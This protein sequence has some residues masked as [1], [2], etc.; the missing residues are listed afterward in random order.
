MTES[1]E[2]IISISGRRVPYRIVR[3]L[4]AKRLRVTVK[5][6]QV[7]VTLPKGVHMSEAERLLQ[8]HGSHR[9]VEF[10][11]VI[12]DGKAVLKPVVR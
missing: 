4:R 10:E 8:Q 2:A 9:T 12:K 7:T 11:V 5:E 3:S 6:G 1:M